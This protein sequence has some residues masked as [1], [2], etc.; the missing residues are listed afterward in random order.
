[1]ARYVRAARRGE[2]FISADPKR[3]RDVKPV[4]GKRTRHKAYGGIA[5][6]RRYYALNLQSWWKHGTIEI[7]LHGGT[8]EFDKI[9]AWGAL[10]AR[11]MDFSKKA[12]LDE[13]IALTKRNDS[14]AVLMELAPSE[15]RAFLTARRDKFAV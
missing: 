3:L 4:K 9:T 11:I 8:T 2:I 10:W 5:E 14:W 15:W 13:V 12:S 1:M 6:G 7:R